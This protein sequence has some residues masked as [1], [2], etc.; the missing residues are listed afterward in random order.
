MVFDLRGKNLAE[1]TDFIFGH[2]VSLDEGDTGWWW[3]AAVVFEPAEYVAHITAVFRNPQS[4]RSQYSRDQLEQGFWFL[5]SGATGGL[6]DVLWNP[7]VPWELRAEL[8]QASVDL[9]QK[10]FAL[11]A[12]DTSAFRGSPR[13]CFGTL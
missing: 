1:V 9:Y 6:N 8:I 3:K 10:F 2:P 13:P 11:D 4:L 5:I 7:D 12:L